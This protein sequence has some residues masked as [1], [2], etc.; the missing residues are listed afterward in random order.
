[1]YFITKSDENIFRLDIRVDYLALGVQVEE[2]FQNLELSIIAPDIPAHNE[3]FTCLIIIF[4][5]IIVA[6]ND[7][8]EQI[9]PK[10]LE[11]IENH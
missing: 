5:F 1:M 10:D 6:L 3:H 7:K 2:T 11:H 8:I 9:M 4:T